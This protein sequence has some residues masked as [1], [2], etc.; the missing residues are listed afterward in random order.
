MQVT[1]AQ[2]K[3]NARFKWQDPEN[4]VENGLLPDQCHKLVV[5]Y[6][7]ATVT[8]EKFEVPWLNVE[9][10]FLTTAWHW[11]SRKTGRSYKLIPTTFLSTLL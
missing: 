3:W 1:K 9:V 10:R 11:N 6:Q 7:V 5:L 8:T 4:C 2:N